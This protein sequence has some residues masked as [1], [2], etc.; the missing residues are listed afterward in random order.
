MNRF[1]IVLL[2][3][4]QNVF[5]IKNWRDVFGAFAGGRG[6]SNSGFMFMS[7]KPDEER[8]KTGD[9]AQVIVNRLRPKVSNMPGAVLYLQAFQDLRIGGRNSATEYQYTLTADSLKDLNE[10]GSVAKLSSVATSA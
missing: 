2:G 7:L 4:T 6:N 5:K 1:G 8:H 3:Q 10:W 9:T